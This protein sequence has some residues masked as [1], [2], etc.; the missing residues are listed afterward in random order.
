MFLN[1]ALR[2]RQAL[3]LHVPSAK[4]V[5]APR[6]CIPSPLLAPRR[7]LL[8][9]RPVAWPAVSPPLAN[10]HGGLPTALQP[11]GRPIAP[12][13]QTAVSPPP[14]GIPVVFSPG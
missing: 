3:M 6:Y 4:K 2:T 8:A 1:T 12:G 10:T 14:R 9:H 7:R 11:R 13:G 5:L